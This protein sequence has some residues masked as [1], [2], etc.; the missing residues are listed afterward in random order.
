MGDRRRVDPDRWHAYVA[1]PAYD[2]RVYTDYAQSLA[3]ASF[4]APLYMVQVSAGVIGNGAFIELARNIFVKMFL[5]QHTECTHLFFIDGDL[6][7]PPNA[8]IGLLRSG[9]PIC[10]GVYPR[11]EEKVSYPAQWT[12]HPT[13]GGL[14]VEDD[15]IMHN[16]VPTGFLCIS[17]K[18]VEEMAA[19]AQKMDIPGQGQV[20]WLFYTKIQDNKFVGEDF[21]FCDDYMKKY[22]KPIPVWADI[23]FSHGGYKGNYLAHLKKLADEL[24][25][26]P[27]EGTNPEMSAA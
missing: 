9:K 27:S 1:T 24:P 18:V 16:R 22:G 20:P 6:K 19:D 4:C 23:D 17:R 5:E 8:F 10:A 15:W 26:H 21:A 7:F 2:G 11:R 14:W 12:T 25:P 13:E 3:E